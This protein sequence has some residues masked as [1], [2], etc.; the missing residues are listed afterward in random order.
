[1]GTVS[2]NEPITGDAVALAD[3]PGP[4]EPARRRRIDRGLLAASLVIASGLTLI[5]W[6]L[7]TAVTGDEGVD[8]PDA[9]E[10]ISPVENAVQVLQQDR[11]VVDLAF[12]YEGT[13]TVD[14]IEIPIT[15]LGQDATEPGDQVTLPPTALFD[16]GNAV[17]SFQPTEGAVI[18]S[19]GEG[20]HEA[21]VTFWRTVD[22]PDESTTYRW[23]FNV[24]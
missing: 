23:S 19:F 10:D 2:T 18:E 14:G 16:P 3:E 22:G 13:L 21:E 24:V 5:G 1:M 20:R 6:G 11:V 17:I 8:R 4:V 9:I 15:V 7:L 12:G